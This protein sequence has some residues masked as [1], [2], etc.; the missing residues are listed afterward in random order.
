MRF[1][2]RSNPIR[3]ALLGVGFAMVALVGAGCTPTYPNCDN[4]E[5]C[6]AKGEHC[7]GGMCQQCRTD[8]H[9]GTCQSCNAGACQAVPGCCTHTGD[10]AVGQAC[11]SGQCGPECLDTGE[12]GAGNKCAD[13]RC[14]PDVECTVDG[15]CPQGEACQQGRCNVVEQ[16]PEQAACQLERVYFDFDSAS[17]SSSAARTL[18]SDAQ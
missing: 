18:Q 15:D 13:G 9:C 3:C 2:E 6:R 7:V 14:V 4:D 1:H 5:H 12:C 10:C 8:E 11:R 17:I 16:A